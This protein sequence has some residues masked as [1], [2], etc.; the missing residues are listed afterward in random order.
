MSGHQL[1]VMVAD[2]IQSFD[3]VDRSILDC[4]LGRLGLPDWF[5]RR[6]FLFIVRVVFGSSLL[7]VCGLGM[8]GGRRRGPSGLSSEH[9]LHCC[10]L[11][12][13]MSVPWV[14]D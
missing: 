6:I 8:G 11:C 13:L 2:V 7:L 14:P 10:S 5:R 3:T 1:H 12:P 9:G 4:T